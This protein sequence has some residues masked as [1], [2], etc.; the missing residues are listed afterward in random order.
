M[1]HELTE[2]E[3]DGRTQGPQPYT[4]CL[5]VRVYSGNQTGC[6]RRQYQSATDSTGS[7]QPVSS[8]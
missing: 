7:T 6:V 4:D 1:L 2:A 5:F 8:Q 3:R